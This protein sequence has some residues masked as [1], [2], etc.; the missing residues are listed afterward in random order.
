MSRAVAGQGG[1]KA[2]GHAG[3]GTVRSASAFGNGQ[4]DTMRGAGN[5][6]L[7]LSHETL[8]VRLMRP[9]LEPS[10]AREPDLVDAAQLVID[11]APARTSQARTR[12]RTRS[13]AWSR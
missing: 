2:E 3:Q 1:A 10:A 4:A 8:K 9:G 6:A 11:A 7:P 13:P 5:P 12:A